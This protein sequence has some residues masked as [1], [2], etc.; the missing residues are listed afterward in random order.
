MHGTDTGGHQ[1]GARAGWVRRAAPAAMLMLLCGMPRPAAAQS[2]I[3]FGNEPSWAVLFDDPALARLVL[4]DRPEVV[5]RGGEVR[6]DPLRE[7]VWRGAPDG[8]GGD[9]VVFLREHDCSDGMSDHVHPLT[10]RVSLPDGRALAGCCRLPAA[11]AAPPRSSAP[12]K[13]R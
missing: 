13:H 8:G 3:C 6:L 5:H 11:G 7:R 9:L 10:A 1:P 4:P 2:L 12:A